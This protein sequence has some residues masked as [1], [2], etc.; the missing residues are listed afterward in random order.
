MAK[1]ESKEGESDATVAKLTSKIDQA[2]VR[3]TELKDEVKEEKARWADL[4]DSDVDPIVTPGVKRRKAIVSKSA[5]KAARKVEEA[6]VASREAEIAL[7]TLEMTSLQTCLLGFKRVEA[8]RLEASD[9]LVQ[10]AIIEQEKA[11]LESHG[12]SRHGDFSQFEA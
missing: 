8:Q 2:S 6:I 5:K 1:T 10:A 3:S 7:K 11:L 9:S 12:L 4:S